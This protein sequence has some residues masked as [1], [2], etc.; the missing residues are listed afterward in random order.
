MSPHDMLLQDEEMT[1]QAGNRERFGGRWRLVSA[2]L[3]NVWRYG[4]LVLPAQSGRLLLRGPNGTGKTT[5]LEALWPF[6]LDLDKTK[7]RAGQ[8]RTTTLTSLMREGWS[9]RKRVGYAWLTFAGPVDEQTRSYGARLVLSNGS[10]PVVRTE[11]FWIPGEPLEDMPLTGPGRATL[12]T[13]EAFR[14]VVEHAGGRV[15]HDVDEYVADLGNQVFSASRRDLLALADRIRTVRNPNLLAATSSDAAAQ[16][17]REALP[18]V[19]AEVIESTGEALAATEETRQALERDEE[20]A[21][22]LTRFAEVWAGH[23]A[24]VAGRSAERAA[25]ARQALAAA[26][27]ALTARESE[28]GTATSELEAAQREV[29]AVALEDQTASA[30]VSAIEKSPAYLAV[31]R[32]ADRRQAADAEA[33]EARAQ[34]S[35]LTEHNDRA[36]R[37]TQGARAEAEQLARAV[38]G[39]GAE[40]AAHDPAASDRRPVVAVLGRPQSVLTVGE[41]S[42][43]PGTGLSVATDPDL[44][45]E[46]SAG[47]AALATGH[48]TTAAGVDLLVR[49]HRTVAAE[50]E[51]ASQAAGRADLAEQAADRESQRRDRAAE[52]ARAAVRDLRQRV[53]AWLSSSADLTAD[54]TQDPLSAQD[55]TD[56]ADTEPAAFLAMVAGWSAAARD[57]AA[58]RAAELEAVAGRVA[59]QARELREQATVLRGRVEQLR[60][61]E[62]LVLPRPDWAGPGQDETAFG[63]AVDWGD[64]VPQPVRDHVESALA[65]A[66]V[67]GAALEQDAARTPAWSLRA[68]G[69]PVAQSLAGLLTVDPG[70]PRAALAARV[71]DRIG[72]TDTAEDLP[73]APAVVG[74]DGTFRFGVL[75][76][77]APG[78]DDPELLPDASHIGAAYRQAAA[79]AEADRLEAEADR[80]ELEAGGLDTRA[81]EL[82]ARAVGVRRRAGAFPDTE[83]LAGAERGRAAAAVAATESRAAADEATDVLRAARERAARVAA[84]WADK[85]KAMGLPQELDALVGAGESAR[86]TAEGLR[87][88]AT[89]MTGHQSALVRL[90]SRVA[91][92]ADDRARLG[93]WHA[94]AVEAHDRA[95]RARAEYAELEETHGQEAAGLTRRL[96]AAQVRVAAAR[97]AAPPAA[98]LLRR[99]D[100][101][102]ATTAERVASAQDRVVEAE[103]PAAATVA[104]LRSLLAVPGV[105]DAVLGEAAPEPEDSPLLRQVTGATAAVTPYGKKRLADE[106]EQARAQL[107]GVWAIDRAEGHG[108]ELDTYQC[109]HDGDLL[110]PSAAASHAR[111][112]AERARERL[113]E[114]EE[115]ALRDFIVGRLPAAIGRAWLEQRDW[116]AGVNRKMGSASASSGVGVRVRT[117]L[118]DDLSPTQRTVHGLACRR[119]AATRSAEDDRELADALKALL[120]AADGETVTD[121]VRA[122]VDV[123]DWVRVDYLVH[124]PG[125]PEPKRWTR[126]TG[127][128]GGERR[129]V[130]L[131]PMLAAVAAIYDNLP[132]T[133]LRLAA[134][135]EVPAEVDERGREGL[136]RYVAEL[137]LDVICTSY[138]WD[139]APGAWD[140]VDAHD[141]EA[142]PDGTVVAFPMLIRGLDPLPGDPDHHGGLDGPDGP[143]DRGSER[144]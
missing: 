113:H 143:D 33:G 114:A 12:T 140:G 74:R 71:L 40:A 80:I 50:H 110:A 83:P 42:V 21:V 56:A 87:R 61:G 13:A 141:L 115:S 95:A 99:S 23:A 138:L 63:T 25:Q 137:D 89:A 14:E 121:R 46:A 68:D 43:D 79:L 34:L 136:A 117:S 134:L 29:A 4:D 100:S 60:S 119:S 75:A 135:D 129:L 30:E 139:G 45:G 65:A 24:D 103:P 85:A 70:H 39:A 20:A 10:T 104:A 6:L 88:C 19:S 92:L 81:A 51:R 76:G 2:G 82:R 28:L 111:A 5:A 36:R 94:A 17:L 107:A 84:A 9:E 96:Q 102:A 101:E 11:P 32:L 123:R 16:A 55:V 8:S 3:S 125:E 73:E 112:L 131:A 1:A 7:L 58:Y 54:D 120:G 22:T 93:G 48:D 31:G 91:N 124:R 66:G 52:A 86:R 26:R 37:D 67:L 118:R 97:T 57:R 53:L 69:P 98:A 44:L 108:D 72:L 144:R 109:T 35:R 59:G 133:A 47:W 105:A 64:A 15:F 116:V 142:G 127:L 78:T 77:R 106:H 41:V 62:L 130:I 122:A 132:P 90:R 49:E 27:R 126:N 18:G 38:A 128:S